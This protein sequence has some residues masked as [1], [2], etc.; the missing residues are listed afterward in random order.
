MILNYLTNTRL[1]IQ[2]FF[3]A[4]LYNYITIA[5]LSSAYREKF[6]GR[7]IFIGTF[8]AVVYAPIFFF[9]RVAIQCDNILSNDYIDN[10]N[11]DTIGIHFDLELR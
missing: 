2:S 9:S 1:L 4:T 8:T 5:F 11:R 7:Y 10:L 6:K 3:C